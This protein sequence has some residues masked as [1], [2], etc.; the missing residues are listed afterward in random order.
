[1]RR[2]VG[3][4]GRVKYLSGQLYSLVGTVFPVLDLELPTG[5]FN[6]MRAVK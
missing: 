4:G 3:E 6:M 1:M 2:V 5:S